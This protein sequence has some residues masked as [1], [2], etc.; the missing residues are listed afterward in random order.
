MISHFIKKLDEFLDGFSAYTLAYLFWPI[1][2]LIEKFQEW[3][4][5][6][7]R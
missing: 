3:G 2:W 5:G 7:K 1:G 6:E 4:G